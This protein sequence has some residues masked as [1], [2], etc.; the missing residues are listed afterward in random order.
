MIN[1]VRKMT[2]LLSNKHGFLSYSNCLQLYKKHDAAQCV[3]HRDV[4]DTDK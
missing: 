4:H 1:D 3:Q 2:S